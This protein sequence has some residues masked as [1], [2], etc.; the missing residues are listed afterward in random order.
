MILADTGIWA[1][2]FRQTDSTLVELLGRGM[3]LMHPYIIGELALG[4]LHHR[5]V[6]LRHLRSLPMLPALAAED[7]L[8][9]IEQR[10]WVARGVGWVDVALLAATLVRNG[11]RLWSRDT[12]LAA[13]ATDEGVAIA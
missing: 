13:L 11:T 8:V 9:A 1:D 2:H 12:R 3:V 7:V 4:R 10:Q 5:A 6:T